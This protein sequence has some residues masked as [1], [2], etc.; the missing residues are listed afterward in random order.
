MKSIQLGNNEHISRGIIMNSDGTY[1]ALTFSKSRDF[2][3]KKGAEKWL[4]RN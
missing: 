3:T 1:T 2:K 4:S